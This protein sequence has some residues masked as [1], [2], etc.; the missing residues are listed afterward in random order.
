MGLIIISIQFN[1]MMIYCLLR[2]TVEHLIRRVIM[3]QYNPYEGIFNVIS[4]IETLLLNSFHAKI[5][6]SSKQIPMLR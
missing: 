1:T 2:A 3:I 5:L 6:E 4:V